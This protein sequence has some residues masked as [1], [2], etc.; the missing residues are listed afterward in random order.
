MRTVPR[1]RRE[2]GEGLVPLMVGMLLTLLAVLAMLTSYRAMVSVSI[3]AT[4]TA[5]R[6]GQAASALLAAQ[7]EL[8]QAGFGINAGATGA[9]VAVDEGG[10]RIVWRFLERLDSTQPK[11]AGLLLVTETTDNDG[12]YFLP[13]ADCDSADAPPSWGG[14]AAPRLIASASVLYEPDTDEED[15]DGEVRSYDLSEAIFST[16]AGQDCGPFGIRREEGNR[17]LVT[18]RDTVNDVTVFSYCLTNT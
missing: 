12:I 11:C 13:P 17:T 6:D 3:P 2:A 1:S 14:S 18:L 10:R 5:L 16:D 9:N 15:V 4:R 8:Q 7:I